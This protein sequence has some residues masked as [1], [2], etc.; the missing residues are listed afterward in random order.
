MESLLS[1]PLF[2][3][4]LEVTVYVKLLSACFYLLT[5]KYIIQLLGRKS[6]KGFFVYTGKGGKREVSE[7]V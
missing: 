7:P 4:F 3:G 2:Q 5:T 1:T 6:G